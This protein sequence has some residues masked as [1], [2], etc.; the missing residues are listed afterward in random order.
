MA[1][2]VRRRKMIEM[3][4]IFGACFS[5]SVLNRFFEAHGIR[6]TGQD[7]GMHQIQ[8]TLGT[9]RGGGGGTSWL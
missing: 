5:L 9:A 7:I 6:H 4:D 1:L 2:A 8:T 3:M